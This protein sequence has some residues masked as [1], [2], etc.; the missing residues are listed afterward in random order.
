MSYST[1][2]IIGWA[3][4]RRLCEELEIRWRPS[5][6]AHLCLLV[7]DN[8]TGK[9]LFRR[10][11]HAWCQKD[12]E[13][14]NVEMIGLSMQDRAGGMMGMAHAFVYGDEHSNAT[15]VNTGRTVTTA[16]KTA[17]GRNTANVVFW[18]EPDTGLSDAYAADVG[19]RIAEFALHPPKHTRAS[20]VVTHRR[21]LME[22]LLRARPH[23]L[24]FGENA[25]ETIEEYLARPVEPA[26]I[27]Q[28]YE[29]SHALFLKV[30]KH[31]KG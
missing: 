26:D 29:R 7:G 8:A 24:L 4:K 16:I 28:L 11:V 1:A 22:Q 2:S 21:A 19:R 15:G 20:F 27:E 10:I 14:K 6:N 18:D 25:P 9:S 12:G 23:V 13:P 31:L 30:S 3:M 5:K 17:E